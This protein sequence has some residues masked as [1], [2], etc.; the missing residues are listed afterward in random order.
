MTYLT[1]NTAFYFWC[2]MGLRMIPLAG[3]LL[4]KPTEGLPPKTS[5]MAAALGAGGA[6]AHP[7]TV[8]GERKFFMI[9][10]LQSVSNMDRGASSRC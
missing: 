4:A 7:G 5:T 3:L 8:P 2:T 6:A 10:I 9:H 1:D